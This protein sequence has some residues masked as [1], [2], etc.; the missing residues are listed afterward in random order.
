M[1][2]KRIKKGQHALRSHGI[3]LGLNLGLKS[4]GSSFL[5]TLRILNHKQ[6]ISKTYMQSIQFERA[7]MEASAGIRYIQEP[8]SHDA[9]LAASSSPCEMLIK[10]RQPVQRR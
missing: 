9:P 3:S 10:V 5:N 6:T 8:V 2:C 7:M 1:K 4:K